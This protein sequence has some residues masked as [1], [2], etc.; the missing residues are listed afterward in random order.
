MACL[1]EYRDGFRAAVLVLGGLVNEYLVAFRVKDRPEIDST[2]CYVPLENSNNFSMLVHGIVQM[3]ETGRPPY[4]VERT[5]LT[6]GALAFLME[7]AWRG[8]RRLETPELK[9]RLHGAGEIVLRAREGVVM[10]TEL[11]RLTGPN[12]APVKVAGGFRAADGPVFSR[13]GYLL[14][15]D[16]PAGRI[17]KW[18]AGKGGRLPREAAPAP[19]ASPSTIRAACWPASAGASP[20]P[21]RT[22]RSPCWPAALAA[23]RDLVYAIDGSIYFTDA[24]VY[25]ITRA[26]APCGWCRASAR[27][28][29][30]L[31]LAPNQQKLYVADA[32]AAATS[33][34]STSRRTARCATGA[35]SPRILGAA[36]ASRPTK[37]AISGSRTAG[38]TV[39]DSHGA[40]LGS[41]AVPEPA[42]NCAWGEGFRNLYV[43]AGGSVYRLPAK[44]NGTRTY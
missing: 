15:C 20:A 11:E 9:H 13:L 14:F 24:A 5:L 29:P 32:A 17:L 10:A 16:V 39:L 38:I 3:F 31:A 43:T 44:V 18:Q 27:G 23:P 42:R 28:P 12:P 25:Q 26:R 1:L 34:S 22:G 7:S 21:K 4:P 36:G 6:T 37:R 33:G 30:G 19:A 35:C 40:R 2:L 8:H 41:I